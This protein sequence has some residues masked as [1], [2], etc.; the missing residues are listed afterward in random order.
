MPSIRACRRCF[1]SL[2]TDR[3][4]AYRIDHGFDHL[5]VRLSI[6]VQRMVRS[7]LGVSGVMFTLDPDSGFDRVVLIEAAYGLGEAVVGGQLDP[8]SFWLFKPTLARGPGAILKRAVGS[9]AWK[10]VL[11]ADGRPQRAAVAPD[12]AGVLS[13]RD[14]EAV[15]LARAARRDRGALQPAPRRADADGHRV[16]Q[17]RR[18]RAALHLAG[19]TGDRAPRAAAQGPRGLHA[20]H[21]RRP[22]DRH[23]QGRRPADRRGAGPAACASAPTC[24]ASRR[25][26]CSWPP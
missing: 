23:R 9:K 11:D 16:G 3:A 4:I 10:L 25:A 21:P 7:D 12:E 13:L 19:A 1:A 18:R 14:A 22:P 24:S 5:A 15:E 26:R 20:L 2:F 6:G 17:G 8:D